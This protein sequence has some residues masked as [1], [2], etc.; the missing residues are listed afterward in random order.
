[1]DVDWIKR[2]LILPPHKTKNESE[3]IFQLNDEM[4]DLLEKL[5]GNAPDENFIFGHR[6]KTSPKQID[7]QYFTQKFR[8]FRIKYSISTKLKFY[9]LKHSSN[10]YD[11]EDGASFYSI[12]EKNRHASLQVTNDYIRNRL[13]KKIVKPTINNRF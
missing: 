2:T 13:L 10:F 6:C 12:M 8:Y 3:A 4:Y 9:A 11:L 7:E 1:M 5:V